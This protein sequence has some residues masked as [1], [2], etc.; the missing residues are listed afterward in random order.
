MFEK[1]LLGYPPRLVFLHSEVYPLF[2][3][4]EDE[5]ERYLLDLLIVSRRLDLEE[6]VLEVAQIQVA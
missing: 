2:M 6:V 3:D 1:E 5:F 4:L